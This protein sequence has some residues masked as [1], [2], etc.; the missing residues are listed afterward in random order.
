MRWLGP[1]RV[2]IIFDNGTVK[3]KTIDDEETTVFTNGHRLRLS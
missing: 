2:E 1:Y 3:L